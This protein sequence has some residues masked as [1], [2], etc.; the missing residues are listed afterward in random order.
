[1]V[2]P[3]TKIIMTGVLEN[4]VLVIIKMGKHRKF[5][6]VCHNV[7]PDSR[8]YFIHYV[9]DARES[10]V[11]VEEYPDTPGHFHVHVFVEYPNPRSRMSVLRYF[12]KHT[13]VVQKPVN[14]NRSWGRVQ[15]DIMYGTMTQAE[16]YLVAPLKQKPVGD[17][18][19]QKKCCINCG[20]REPYSYSDNCFRCHHGPDMIAEME[21]DHKRELRNNKYFDHMAD[22]NAERLVRYNADCSAQRVALIM[23]DADETYVPPPAFE[24]RNLFSCDLWHPGIE[25]VARHLRFCPEFM[26]ELDVM[27]TEAWQRRQ[28]R[29]REMN[30]IRVSKID[31]SKKIIGWD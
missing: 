19:R 9:R 26:G 1:M 28:Q 11:S 31:L 21:E 13:Q 6:V 23:C 5:S 7:R 4:T 18:K 3:S 10:T 8:D 29:I 27:Y 2:H 25:R 24:H 30:A 17:A 20:F 14:E 22:W 15:V 16:Q 12:E